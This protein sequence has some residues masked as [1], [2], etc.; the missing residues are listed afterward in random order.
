MTV[1]LI[2]VRRTLDEKIF[3]KTSRP[4]SSKARRKITDNGK[5]TK[6]NKSETETI[7][8]V[9]VAISNLILPF[10]TLFIAFGLSMVA[11]LMIEP[12]V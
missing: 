2:I 9:L 8:A 12:L 5:I 7:S 3:P 6:R 1:F 10:F 4:V 11:V